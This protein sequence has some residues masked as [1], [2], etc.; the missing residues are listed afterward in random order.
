L[1]KSIEYV[2]NILAVL[3]D[4]EQ[5]SRITAVH[6]RGGIGRTGTPALLSRADN[7][8][9][10]VQ[11]PLVVLRYGHRLLARRICDCQGRR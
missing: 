9:L 4:N 10:I 6:C 3:K 5:R 2:R 8:L 11:N 7:R 1:P